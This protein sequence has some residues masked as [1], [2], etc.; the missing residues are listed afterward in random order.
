MLPSLD[1][2]ACF[3]AA[4][5][6]FNF[7]RASKRIG[8]TPT[9][10]GQ[11]IRQLEEQLGSVLFERTTRRVALTPAGHA[12]LPVARDALD[13][14]RRCSTVLADPDSARVSL[15]L[16]TR[17]ELGLSWIV[18]WL[19]ELRQ[20]RPE[21]TV[22]LYFGSGADLLQRLRGSQVDV[23]VT[24]APIARSEWHQE[25]LHPE[26]YVFCASPEL[27]TARP[28]DAAHQA[29][30]HTLLDLNHDQPLSRYLLSAAPGLSFSSVHACGTA[31]AVCQLALGGFGV[32]VVPEYMVRRELDDGRLVR[33]LPEAELL[34]DSFRMLWRERSPYSDVLMTLAESLRAR[35]LC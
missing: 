19:I 14:A 16:G 28:L 29:A 4:A 30:A 6:Q 1:S 22:E 2:L 15:T 23:V 18:P 12:L 10:F 31:A 17:F 7:S 27:L 9:A 25:V 5:E 20:T 35:P 33:I 21:L 13:A 32:A 24:S 8:I 34:T 26:T 11:R 3:V